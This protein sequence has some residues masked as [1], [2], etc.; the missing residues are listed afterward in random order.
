MAAA[1]CSLAL[2]VSA[3]VCGLLFVVGCGSQHLSA[4]AAHMSQLVVW[5]VVG[6]SLSVDQLTL[7]I[8]GS[9]VSLLKAL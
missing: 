3:F 6:V 2:P 8:S 9:T 1:V 7:L 5:C 4:L